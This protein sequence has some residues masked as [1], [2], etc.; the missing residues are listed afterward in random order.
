MNTLLTLSALP[1]AIAPVSAAA[2]DCATAATAKPAIAANEA[3]V[4]EMLAYSL[5]GQRDGIEDDCRPATR[6]VECAD[7][8]EGQQRQQQ[9]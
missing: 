4:R 9:A 5:E 3:V 6:P 1:L 8:P 2:S 7:C